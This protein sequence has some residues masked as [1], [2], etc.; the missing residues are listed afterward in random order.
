MLLSLFN[1]N[2]TSKNAKTCQKVELPQLQL[3]RDKF[4]PALVERAGRL[5][6]HG[7]LATALS[8]WNTELSEAPW[9]SDGE[10]LPSKSVSHPNAK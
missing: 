6:L 4:A 7:R 10:D 8:A 5:N 1:L 9:G 2:M 3:M